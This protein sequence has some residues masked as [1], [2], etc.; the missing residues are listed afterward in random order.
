MN[1]CVFGDSL[2]RGV[3]LDVTKE[4]YRTIKECFANLLSES[5][6]FEL[7]NFS[8]F[9]CTVTKGSELVRRH[10]NDIARA[11]YTVIEFGGNDSDRI[12][13]DISA[14]PNEQHKAITPPERFHEEYSAL[15]DDVLAAGGHPIL[16]N[17]PPIDA[18]RYFAWFSRNLNADNILHWL[19]GDIQYIYRWHEQYSDDIGR[20]AFEKGVRLIDI[21]S[22]FLARRDF[23]ALLCGDGIHPSIEGHRLISDTIREAAGELL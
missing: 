12:W 16:L 21:R 17:L 9:G 5:L 18:E 19:G 1:I 2:A 23:R 14:A 6:G 8:K 7:E 20:I 15:I 22:A 11:D 3:V 13:S 10:A 4:K